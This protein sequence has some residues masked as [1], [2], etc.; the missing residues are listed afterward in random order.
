[1]ELS[2]HTQHIPRKPQTI[3]DEAMERLFV[4]PEDTPQMIDQL[5]NNWDSFDQT[6][7]SKLKN[8]FTEHGGLVS[9][10]EIDA[11]QNEETVV[12]DVLKQLALHGFNEFTNAH[13][14]YTM[15]PNDGLEPNM[16]LVRLRNFNLK[17]TEP[18]R[19]LS[20]WGMYDPVAYLNN[21]LLEKGSSKF[22]VV[23]KAFIY[24]FANVENQKLFALNP[25]KYL[26][27]PPKVIGTR[28]AVKNAPKDGVLIQSIVQSHHM[29]V[30]SVDDYLNEIS[31]QGDKHPM[32]SKVSLIRYF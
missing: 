27:Q 13:L 11:Y 10:M 26:E 7:I 8:N 28:I 29:N 5:L 22:V 9:W 4:Q 19:N 17:Q 20:V 25:E 1:M 23:Y 32:Y 30:F 24:A 12:Q 21:T 6:V 31:S 14:P 15:D 3:P 18:P 2:L 16:D